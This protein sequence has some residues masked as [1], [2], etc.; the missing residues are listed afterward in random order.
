M[1]VK[2]GFILIGPRCAKRSALVVR[3]VRTLIT[4][5][6]IRAVPDP[7]RGVALKATIKECNLSVEIR[8]SAST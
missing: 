2:L 1:T 8:T 3:T 6:T 5:R 7:S 4:V